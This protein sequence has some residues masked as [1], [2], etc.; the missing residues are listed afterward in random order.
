MS[1]RCAH[2]RCC[3]VVVPSFL[4]STINFKEL[5]LSYLLEPRNI[6]ILNRGERERRRPTA[7][8]FD[9]EKRRVLANEPSPFSRR[10]EPA[11]VSLSLSLSRWMR[12]R[13]ASLISPSLLRFLPVD[14]LRRISFLIVLVFLLSPPRPSFSFLY[15]SLLPYNFPCLPLFLSPCAARS[16][17]R[18]LR[19]LHGTTARIGAEQRGAAR[20]GVESTCRRCIGVRECANSSVRVCT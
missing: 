5:R 19:S 13:Y 6:G 14:S 7:F 11:H 20:R 15:R 17:T 3:S 9:E 16:R 8:G 4:L 18:S 10:L 2:C 12:K 1:N